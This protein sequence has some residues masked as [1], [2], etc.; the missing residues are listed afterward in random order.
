MSSHFSYREERIEQLQLRTQ[1]SYG[2]LKLK[3]P[4]HTAS[5][6]GQYFFDGSEGIS[7]LGHSNHMTDTLENVLYASSKITRHLSY[8]EKQ[9]E[10]LQQRKT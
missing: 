5:L 9:I 4:S 3:F 7:R 8:R 2:G 1:R 10:Q 6:R